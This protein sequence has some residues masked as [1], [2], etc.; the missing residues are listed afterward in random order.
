[1]R[2]PALLKDACQLFL[3]LIRGER[4]AYEALRAQLDCFHDLGLAPLGAD[5]QH[6]D[7]LLLARRVQAFLLCQERPEARLFGREGRAP[8]VQDSFQWESKSLNRASGQRRGQCIQ[9]GHG[10]L[11]GH[12][13]V[14]I[15]PQKS[16]RSSRTRM[17]ASR[18]GLVPATYAP[19]WIRSSAC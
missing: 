18:R 9:M 12:A 4:F 3:D 14:S 11:A 13:N 10:V 16:T 5:H 8:P 1:M 6:G 19:S 2:V 7:V 17:L 15:L